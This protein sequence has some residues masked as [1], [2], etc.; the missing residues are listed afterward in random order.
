MQR[1]YLLLLLHAH[2]PFVRH[3]EH[4]QFLEERW[5][6]QAIGECYL[7]LLRTLETLVGEGLPCRIT[8]SLSPTLLAMLRDPLLQRRFLAYQDAQIGLARVQARERRPERRKLARGYLQ[9]FMNARDAYRDRYGCD[10]PA[11]F[12]RFE[13]AGLVALITS[14]ATHGYLPLLCQEPVAVRAQLHVAADAFE[15]CFGHRPAGIWLPEC[16]YYPELEVELEA[17]GY[18]YFFLESHGIRHARPRPVHGVRQPIACG[19]ALAAF[20]RDPDCSNRVWSREQGYPGHPLYR[21]YHRDIGYEL[22]PEALGG[23]ALAAGVQGPVGIKYHRITCRESMDKD[24]YDPSSAREQARRDARD[25]VLGRLHGLGDSELRDRPPLFVAPYD[26]ELFGHWWY[27]G[28][29]WLEQLVRELAGQE[30]LEMI[31]A[32][33][34]LARHPVLPRARPSVSS[35]GAGGYNRYWLN[36]GNAW[37]YPHL[38]RAAADMVTLARTH[39]ARPVDALRERALNQAARSL[40]LA[41]ASDWPFMIHT[42]SAVEY[43]VKRVT[44]QLSRFRYLE[45]ALR[46]GSLDERRLRAM[47]QMDNL[48]PELDYRIYAEQS[49][50]HHPD[51]CRERAGGQDR[52]PRGFRRRYRP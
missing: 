35:W 24:Y 46:E 29:L 28:P 34:Y 26:A 44:E 21:E 5:L 1:G 10:L 33:D 36:P 25:F 32:P 49:H 47:E 42:G 13:Q 16:G 31:A 43:A 11:A 30:S 14:A 7:P 3:P 6:F 15:A 22:G 50:V 17:V 20:G 8:L 40:L 37:L 48:F 18:R 52:R 23:L 39:A 38:H 19:S 41:Q 2:L 4:E 12:A 45:Q 51:Q 27:E 9:E